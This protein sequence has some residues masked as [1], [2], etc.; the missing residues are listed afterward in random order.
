MKKAVV[1]ITIMGSILI[2]FS[3]MIKFNPNKVLILNEIADVFKHAVYL[4]YQ[5]DTRVVKKAEVW[6]IRQGDGSA[7]LTNE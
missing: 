5:I 7:V 3:L 1:I 2:S 6:F 4:N